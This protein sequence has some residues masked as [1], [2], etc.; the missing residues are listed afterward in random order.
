MLL[1]FGHITILPY[2]CADICKICILHYS[3][4]RMRKITAF[5][6]FLLLTVWPVAGQARGVQQ[7]RKRIVVSFADSLAQRASQDLSGNM[8]GQMSVSAHPVQIEQV[9]RSIRIESNHVQILPI[10]TQSGTF[11]M[12]FRLNKG[13]NWLSGLP[14]G[15]YYMNN[16]QYT[17]N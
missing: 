9:G 8:R 7:P 6:F 4:E 1:P 11:Y 16:R 10:Y 14:R 15:K 2:L 17:I 3:H 12:I 5:I 13:T